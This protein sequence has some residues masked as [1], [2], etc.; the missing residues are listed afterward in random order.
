MTTLAALAVLLG[1]GAWA[2][3]RW[4]E[5]HQHADDLV[6]TVLSTPIPSDVRVAVP[7]TTPRTGPAPADPPSAGAGPTLEHPT[8]TAR[9]GQPARSVPGHQ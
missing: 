3:S 1:A 9:A 2:A 4:L 5:A 7:P 8:P 6:T